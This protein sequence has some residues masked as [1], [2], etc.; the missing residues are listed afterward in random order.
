[1]QYAERPENIADESEYVTG[2]DNYT[3]YLVECLQQHVNLQGINISIYRTKSGVD[4]LYMISGIHITRF[5]TYR[6][7]MNAIVCVLDTVRTN[8]LTLWNK[9]HSDNKMESF[10]FAWKLG[11]YLIKPQVVTKMLH[12]YN[13]VLL[14]L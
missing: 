8:M 1:M 3:K 13:G 11:Q 5:E 2:T 10:D 14:L 12:G 6:W 9:I 4:V 7:T